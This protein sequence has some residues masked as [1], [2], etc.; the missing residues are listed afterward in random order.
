MHLEV[1]RVSVYLLKLNTL[2]NFKQVKVKWG[3]EIMYIY[4][5]KVKWTR[6]GDARQ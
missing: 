5:E 6:C 2:H 3:K 1:S 4:N